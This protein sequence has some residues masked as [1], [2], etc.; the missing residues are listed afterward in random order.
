[1]A[2]K[3]LLSGSAQGAVAESDDDKNE[4]EA[5]PGDPAE[6]DEESKAPAKGKAKSKSKAE[7][8]PPEDETEP[9]EPKAAAVAV[10]QDRAIVKACT[11]AG[12]ADMAYGFMEAGLTLAQVQHRLQ[13][14]P[15]IR[16]ALAHASRTYK[17]IAFPSAEKCIAGGKSTVEVKAEIF[18]CLRAAQGDEMQTHRA[19]KAPERMNGNS[20]SADA[21]WDA[22]LARLGIGDQ[23]KAS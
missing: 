16:S 17:D 15:A 5:A 20:A 10:N 12:A 3:T 7:E 11:E 2:R 22:A 13:D 8:M 21:I 14:A 9:E 18:D 23:N 19:D 1:M 6:T 4:M